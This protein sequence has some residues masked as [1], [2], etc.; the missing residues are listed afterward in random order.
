MI[1]LGKKFIWLATIFSL[2]V[3]LYIVGL[4]FSREKNSEMILGVS[5]SPTYARYLQL[6]AGRAFQWVLDDLGF[7]YLRLSAQWNEVEKEQGKYDYRDLDWYVWQAGERQAK[8]V[9]VMGQKSPRW[10]ECHTP[11][12]AKDLTDA[13]YFS[14]L[15][16]YISTTVEHYKNNPTIEIWQI[17]NEPFLAFGE[18]CRTLTSAELAKEI[19]AAKKVDNGR[20]ILVTDSGELS[21]WRKTATAGDLFGTT[22][23]R[24]VWNEYTGYW[25]YNWLPAAFYKLKFWFAGREYKTA[26][27]AEL[28]AEPWLPNQ[29]IATVS[30]SE[31]NK[32]MSLGQLQKNI[33]YASRLLVSRSYLWGAEW[34]A[35]LNQRGYIEIPNYIK[36]LRKN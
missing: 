4:I 22:L 12:W 21:S 26:M 20:P 9:L 25:S 14:A 35:W 15:E 34:W 24:V 6:D 17:E 10:P 16:N 18:N 33:D 30:L 1:K 32:S 28:Q 27:V 7:R 29:D 5:F 13:E 19:L 36:Q 3:I 23:Y 2:L 11:G 8:V 31:Q